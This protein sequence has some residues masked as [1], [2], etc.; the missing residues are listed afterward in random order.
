MLGKNVRM[1]RIMDRSTGRAVI[2][3]MDH[4]IS[5]GPIEGLVDMRSTIDK[6]SQGGATA[7]VLHKGIIPYSHRSFGRD[8]GL[9]MHL[10][11][12]TGISPSPNRKVIVTTVEE[13]IK[14][15]A[16]AV[17]IHV[18]LGDDHEAD[19]L[20]DFGEVSRKCMEWGMPLMVMIYPRGKDI[21][22]AYDVDLIKK[23][24]RTAIELGADIIKTNYTGEIE[25][26]KEVVRGAEAPV[27][28]AGGPKMDSDERLLQMVKDSMDAGGKGVSI[29]RNVFQ[30]RNVI[31]ITKAI[32]GI[33]LEDM[34]VEEALKIL[35]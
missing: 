30:H 8:I 18:N 7:I 26:F 9:I 15:G 28:I 6:V 17:S 27:I 31:G 23:C 12:S 35:K 24:A 11:A 16:D 21:K 2:V 3:P 10:S 4:G 25:S 5:M 22:D 33:V 14:W 19:M 34:D 29:G 1:E 13:A 32:S 20:R